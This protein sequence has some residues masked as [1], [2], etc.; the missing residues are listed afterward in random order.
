[1]E[2]GLNRFRSLILIGFSCVSQIG[3]S[4]E[5]IELRKRI[6]IDANALKTGIAIVAQCCS[7]L[8]EKMDF[9]LLHD[10]AA[11]KIA[12]FYE[13][14]TLDKTKLNIII[15]DLEIAKKKF[16]EIVKDILVI[17]LDTINTELPN[18]L[19]AGK[20]QLHAVI[21]DKIREPQAYL[22]AGEPFLLETINQFR[23][24]PIGESIKLLRK[25]IYG[26]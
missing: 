18:L 10:C 1:M 17:E 9:K 24:G 2:F 12:E 16:T 22:A 25:E 13:S 23:L 26:V 21:S 6:H 5:E 20:G 19:Q 15:A 3:F 4:M 11:T 7:N 8:R 14:Q